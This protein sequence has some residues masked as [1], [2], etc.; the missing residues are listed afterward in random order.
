M[1]EMSIPLLYLTYIKR[2][3]AIIQRLNVTF[4]LPLA[5]IATLSLSLY[6]LL[7]STL[8]TLFYSLLLSST[9]A[10]LSTLFCYRYNYLPVIANFLLE[11]E[12]II[13]HYQRIQ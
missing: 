3:S 1:A 5:G 13:S 6:S 11:S 12:N 10:T 4:I 2:E 9:I 7:L 8:P